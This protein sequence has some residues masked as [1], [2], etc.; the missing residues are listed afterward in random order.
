MVFLAVMYGWESWTIKNAECQRINAFELRCWRRLLRVP[1]TARRLNQSILREINLEYLLQGL[2]LKMK[3][4]HFG[5]LM[6][7]ADSLEKA[8]MLGKIKGWRRR[9]WQR[10]VGWHHRLNGHDFEQ[11]PGDAEGHGGLVCCSPS[12]HRVRHDWATE[13]LRLQS[14]RP[15]H[16]LRPTFRPVAEG[17]RGRKGVV[18]HKSN[19]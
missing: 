16:Y 18:I 14:S 12:G 17:D 15:L 13:Q 10:M 1:W 3:L 5:H 19:L 6:W 11:A 4:Q 9:G 7:R 8:L 2:V